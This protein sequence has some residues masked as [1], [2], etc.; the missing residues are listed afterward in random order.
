MRFMGRVFMRGSWGRG[1]GGGGVERGKKQKIIQYGAERGKIFA[2]SPRTA[3]LP[4]L[5][6]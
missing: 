6:L 5:G 1:G 4:S 3:P 2:G